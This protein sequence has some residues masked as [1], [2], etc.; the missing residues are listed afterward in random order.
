MPLHAGDIVEEVATG[1]EGRVGSS[2]GAVGTPDERWL[3]FFSDGQDSLT[4]LLFNMDDLRLIT[5]PH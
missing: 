4:K 5:C 1:R 3:V 2:Y